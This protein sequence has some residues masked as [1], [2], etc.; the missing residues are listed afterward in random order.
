[1]KYAYYPDYLYHHGIL[2]MKWGIRRYQNEDGTWT[3]AGL[4]H[5]RNNN[6]KPTNYINEGG[7]LKKGSVLYRVGA[8]EG[9]PTAL[10]RKYFSTNAADHER[11]KNALNVQN[12]VVGGGTSDLRYVTTKDIKIA[13]NTQVGKEFMDMLVSIDDEAYKVSIKDIELAMSHYPPKVTRSASREEQY[14]NIATAL[15]ASQTKTGKDFVNRMLKSEYG[16]VGDING[17]DVS[18]DPIIIFEPDKKMTKKYE[19][20]IS[21]SS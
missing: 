7:T 19:R 4:K 21:R 20:Y 9:D 11:W 13:S 14:G 5:R 15:I 10:N 3:E 8:V 18:E 17:T 6:Y 2:G 12:L 16:G 1:M